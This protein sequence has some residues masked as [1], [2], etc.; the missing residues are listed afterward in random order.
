MPI[1]KPS[2]GTISGKSLK[3]ENIYKLVQCFAL[4]FPPE[5][6]DGP[7]LLTF[8]QHIKVQHFP[9]LAT[10]HRSIA[11]MSVIHHQ[12][13]SAIHDILRSV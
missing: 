1:L 9:I 2:P 6:A 8:L 12:N 3:H 10:L 5:N 11:V 7:A 13:K 4:D